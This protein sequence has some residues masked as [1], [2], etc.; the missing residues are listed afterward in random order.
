MSGSSDGQLTKRCGCRS[1][2]G[3]Q[4]GA[5]C[6]RLRRRDGGWSSTHGTWGYSVTVP[7][8]RG[9]RKRIQR[10]G[11]P[12]ATEA[13]AG[14][15]AA[16][17]RA[18]RGVTG[19]DLLT[20]DQHLAEWIEQKEAKRSTLKEYERHVAW[21]REQVGHVRLT[22]L[23]PSH[24]REA[25]DTLTLSAGSKQRYKNT[26]SSALSDA[27]GGELISTNAARAVT[28]KDGGRRPP[29]RVWTAPRVE[30]WRATGELPGP[31]RVWPPAITG[32]FLDYAERV[33]P[34]QPAPRYA[35]W[36]LALVWG[37][38]RGELCGLRWQDVDVDG[39]P[40]TLA[41]E[42][43]IMTDRGTEYE[44]VPKTAA[45]RRSLQ[46]D[47]ATVD[48]LRAHRRRQTADRLRAG[49]GWAGSGRVFTDLDGATV[50]PDAFGREFAGALKAAG[51][52]PIRL[53]DT[54]HCAATL[55]LGG[56]V[57]QRV[58]Q[59]VLGHAS[60]AMTASYTSVLPELTRSAA[61]AVTAM[62]PRAT[63]TGGRTSV[64][65]P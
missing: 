33:D 7:G 49:P 30:H 52:P 19:S 53:H 29:P 44:D 37:L 55:A 8:P 4:L 5:R 2:D 10:G 20:V 63:G 6:P 23:R 25:I 57:E 18:A 41:V 51:V 61:E 50:D 65:Q 15:D 11:Y 21:W 22:D 62:I 58:V 60:A 14:R 3:R 26:L 45:G 39:D 35:A 31:V 54:R 12:T 13:R 38:R 28:V 17:Q 1:D 59:E 64:T 16:R 56:K 43:T 9:T 27:I 32:E 36:Y 40:A 47:P 34:D 46:L 24:V 48:V 42:V